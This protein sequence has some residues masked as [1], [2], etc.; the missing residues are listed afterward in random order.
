MKEST[1]HRG[2][3]GVGSDKPKKR[4]HTE[5]EADERRDWQKRRGRRR[6]HGAAGGLAL[7][8]LP[9]PC[10]VLCGPLSLSLKNDARGGCSLRVFAQ[11]HSLIQS[12]SRKES[13]RKRKKEKPGGAG[14]VRQRDG[15]GGEDS[16]KQARH[17][18]PPCR[19]GGGGR[20]PQQSGRA[21]CGVVGEEE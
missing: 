21:A 9:V 11:R 19:W 6:R 12:K 18:K 17:T 15:D 16:R 10:R 14:D 13:R 4:T 2:M 1:V 7:A 20:G 3:G 5:E 8:R